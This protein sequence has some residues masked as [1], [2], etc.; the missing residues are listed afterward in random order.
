MS[1]TLYLYKDNSLQLIYVNSISSIYHGDTGIYN[2][3]VLAS[4]SL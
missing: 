2:F 4:R 1:H 3:K